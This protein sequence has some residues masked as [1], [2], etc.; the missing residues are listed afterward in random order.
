MTTRTVTLPSATPR[1][2]RRRRVLLAGAAV[3]VLAGTASSVLGAAEPLGTT[4]DTVAGVREI[5]VTVD[6]GPVS[7]HGGAG[8]DVTVR[9]TRYGST[10]R[11]PDAH[12]RLDGGVLTVEADCAGAFA[13]GCHVADDLTVP[14][15]IPVRVRTALGAIEAVDL[16]VPRFDAETGAGAVSASFVRPPSDVQATSSAG[17]IILRVPDAGYAVDADTA[18][19]STRVAVVADPRAPRA[20]TVRTAAGNVSVLPR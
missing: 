17:N 11:E 19:G 3:L 16:D 2:P 7:L 6:A 13:G 12:V 1:R 5:V 20:L 4:T 15:G 8:P 10:F 18:A 9:T 14:P